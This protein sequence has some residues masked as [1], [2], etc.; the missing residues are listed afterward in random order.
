M[1]WIFVFILI[2]ACKTKP[3]PKLFVMTGPRSGTHYSSSSAYS[4]NHNTSSRGWGSPQ[5]YSPT[6][7]PT[8]S[9]LPPPPQYQREGFN[10]KM[11]V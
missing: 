1:I 8:T 11:P 5:S 3:E 10:Y 4:P 6:L 9:S 2:K 7:Q